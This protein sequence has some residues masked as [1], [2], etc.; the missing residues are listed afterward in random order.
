MNPIQYWY[1]SNENLKKFIDNYF[2]NHINLLS[3]SILKN[4]CTALF[5]KGTATE[6][7]QVLTLLAAAKLLKQNNQ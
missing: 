6:K 5:N 7:T 1:D 4:D 3:D 2:K